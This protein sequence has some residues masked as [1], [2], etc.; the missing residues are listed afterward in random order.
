MIYYLSGTVVFSI[1]PDAATVMAFLL[2]FT[3]VG[4]GVVGTTLYTDY[5][6]LEPKRPRFLKGLDQHAD[7]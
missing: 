2:W 5:C 7:S 4:C 3:G 6:G 1:S